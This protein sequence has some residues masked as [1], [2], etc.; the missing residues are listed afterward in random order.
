MR[1]RTGLACRSP[2]SNWIDKNRS[3][4]VVPAPAI[5]SAPLLP[6]L[7][8]L[9]LD[10]TLVQLLEERCWLTQGLGGRQF[11]LRPGADGARVIVGQ[12]PVGT[13]LLLVL[14]YVLGAEQLPIVA[15]VLVE[16]LRRVR[17]DRRQDGL[18]VVDD[19]HA[20]RDVDARRR[21]LPVLL[22]LEPRRLT[23][24]VAVGLT[25]QG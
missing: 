9:L 20:L 1:L 23:V 24:Q 11:T 7:R 19:A 4:D 12:R 13:H 14:D 3:R 21:R 2:L 6:K 22:D 16:L 25:G 10:H 15:Q 8:V 18:Q 5:S 17:Q